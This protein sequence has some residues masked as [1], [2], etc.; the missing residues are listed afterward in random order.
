M[1]VRSQFAP[2][3]RASNETEIDK[4]YEKPLIFSETIADRYIVNEYVYLYNG[5]LLIGS[6]ILAFDWYNFRRS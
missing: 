2:L 1:T 6:R 3:A 4:I 5:R